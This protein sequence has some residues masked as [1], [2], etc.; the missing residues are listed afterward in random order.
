MAD[1]F[2]L[3]TP[4][5]YTWLQ[6]SRHE[7]WLEAQGQRLLDFSKTSRVADGFAALD[8]CGR[9]QTGAVAET[10]ITAR[11]THAYAL[12]MLL[13]LPGC[14][15]LVAH[16]VQSLLGPLRDGLN[17]GWLPK[18]TDT[19]GRKLAY[20]HAF[21]GLAASSA[22]VAGVQGADVLL[23][24]IVNVLEVHFWSDAEGVMRESFAS[25]WSDEENYRGA[26]SNMHSVEM[27]MAL[28]D[29]LDDPLWRRRA[30]RIATRVIHENARAHRYRVPEHFDRHWRLDKSYNQ[31]KPHDDLRPFGMTPGHFIEWSHLLLK[32]E[33]ALLANG[34]EAPAW[35]VEDAVQLFDAGVQTGWSADGR[36]GIVYTIGWDD[37]PAVRSRAHWVHAE[38]ITAA[39]TLL[40]RT[41]DI[42]YE[43]WYRRFWD[44]VDL[45][46][47]DR[48]LGSW[49]NEVDPD[50]KPSNRIYQGKP[51]LYHA[52]QAT[53]AATLP[54]AP[55]IA[56]LLSER[57]GHTAGKI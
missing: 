30:L 19:N 2:T 57:Q 16:G 31:D 54:L 21:V 32:L 11:M 9:V 14:A 39:A 18:V 1:T 4:P 27:C 10:I 48:Q 43:K 42:R 29:V 51:D 23:N 3:I 46:M 52:Y 20:A 17:D 40:K 34:E 25:D 28:A 26:N 35:L 12:G 44:F 7:R 50:G 49:H 33:A 8:N 36:P 22:H 53:L 37:E 15:P 55:S 56:T 6:S 45:N 38:A 41:G 5:G 24:A 47:I 13:G